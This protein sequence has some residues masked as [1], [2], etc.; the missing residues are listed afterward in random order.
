MSILDTIREDDRE[1]KGEPVYGV[2]P[3]VVTNN[4]DPEGW[5]RV[6]IEIPWLIEGETGWVQVVTLMSGSQRGSFFLPEV[7]DNVLVA[8]EHGDINSP[9]VIGS[10]WNGKDKP[11]ETNKDG[12][13]NI[14]K[15][16]SRS[17]HEF[18]FDDT[19]QKEKVE[20]KTNAKHKIILDDA[21]GKEKIEIRDKA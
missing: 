8:F 5:G 10:L 4:K 21:R 15:F 13:N 14:R 1:V 7:G 18:V 19:D 12:Q 3:A 17:G 2:V 20:I 9:Y 16:K 6:K 11:P